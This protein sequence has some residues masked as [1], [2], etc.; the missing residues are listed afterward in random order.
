MNE[1]KLTFGGEDVNF[2]FGLGF[3]GEVLAIMKCDVSELM[4]QLKDNPFKVVPILMTESAKY[5]ALRNK[6]D[7]EYSEDYFVDLLDN[8]EASFEKM[9]KFVTAFSQSM[10]KNVPEV[11]PATRGNS[12]KA[13]K[14]K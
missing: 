8:D 9:G 4:N 10:T 14:K 1:Y 5:Y 7:K 13:T 3:L 2:K 6:E 11:N 12:K